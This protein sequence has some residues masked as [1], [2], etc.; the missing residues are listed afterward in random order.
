MEP[1]NASNET[2]SFFP[3]QLVKLVHQIKDEQLQKPKSNK[4][5]H[6]GCYACAGQ[7]GTASFSV[8]QGLCEFSDH[9]GAEDSV[10][11]SSG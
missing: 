3:N 1:L 2:V 4:M 11:H 10:F 7:S 6:E 9:K 8:V 5:L